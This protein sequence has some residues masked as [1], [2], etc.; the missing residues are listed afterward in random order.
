MA[1]PPGGGSDLTALT[2]LTRLTGLTADKNDI[3]DVVVGEGR[4]NTM[5]F[6]F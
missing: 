4:C 3:V 1:T 5:F 2:V 6:F